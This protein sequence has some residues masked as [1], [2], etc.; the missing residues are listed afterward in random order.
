MAEITAQ[1]VK[2]LREKTAAG[3]MEC[4]TALVEAKGDLAEAEVV[5]RKRGLASAAKKA[6]RSTKQGLIGVHIAEDGKSGALVEVNCE[7]DF[8]SRTEEFQQMVASLSRQVVAESPASVEALKTEVYA[9]DPTYTVAALLKAKIAKIGEN[10]NIPRFERRSATGILGSYVHP[11]AQL[12]VLVDLT[13]NKP[14]TAKS[15][16]FKELL[17]DVAMQVAAADPRF[18]RREEVTP[19]FLNQEREIQRARAVAEGKPE[20][21]VDKVV[22]GRMSK[23]YEEVCLLDQPF[24]KDNALS[25][26]QYLAA[27]GKELGDTLDVAAFIRYKVGEIVVAGEPAAQ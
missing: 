7:S 24:I 22:E 27:K 26:A 6:T 21:I 25:M 8:V 14:G 17:H 4:K 1:L 13:S 18:V 5:L 19:E 11:G 15:E 12:A 16:A 23:Y 3:M 20:K 10:M 2:Q 9:A